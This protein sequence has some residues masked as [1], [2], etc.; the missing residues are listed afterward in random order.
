MLPFRA[1]SD[2]G[3]TGIVVRERI[4]NPGG[5]GWRSYAQRQCLALAEGS[6]VVSPSIR[7]NAKNGKVMP[8]NVK[9]RHAE[10]RW[11]A[12]AAFEESR[13]A[14]APVTAMRMSQRSVHLRKPCPPRHHYSLCIFKSY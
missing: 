6:P 2:I 3:T 9:A 10:T 13:N 11:N 4:A 8:S 14:L 12:S 5:P 7:S 1:W